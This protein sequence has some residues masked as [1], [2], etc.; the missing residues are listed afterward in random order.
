MTEPTYLEVPCTRGVTGSAFVQGVQDFQFSCGV[1][2]VWFPKKS[3]FKVSMS[4]YANGTVL[5]LAPKALTAFADNAAVSKIFRLS[6]S[7]V[8]RPRQSK[9]DS[10]I[11]C[12]GS[13]LWELLLQ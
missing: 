7:I 12:L 2:N 4:L 1:P 13:N 9:F 5:P 8:L 3:Y 11:L 6:L 10:A